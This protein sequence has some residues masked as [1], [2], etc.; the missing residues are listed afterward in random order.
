MLKTP[1]YLYLTVNTMTMEGWDREYRDKD[2]FILSEMSDSYMFH[3]PYVYW[4]MYRRTDQR[5]GG[6]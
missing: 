1:E 3:I 6:K 4:N 2:A 5:T